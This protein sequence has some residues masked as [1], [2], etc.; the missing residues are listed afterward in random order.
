MKI[1]QIAIRVHPELFDEVIEN[2][3]NM[4]GPTYEDKLK[5]DGFMMGVASRNIDLRLAFNH[6]I[7]DNCEIEFICSDSDS[8]W[9]SGEGQSDIFLSHLGIYCDSEE[10]FDNLSETFNQLSVLQSTISR[11]HSNK[12]EGD[13]VKS[14]RAYRDTIFDTEMIFGFN[15]KL[16]LKMR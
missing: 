16:S 1:S 4:M 7:M 14:S 8:H 3:N 12:R 9:H 2:F 11:N 10:E 15:I 13:N 6:T 5:M